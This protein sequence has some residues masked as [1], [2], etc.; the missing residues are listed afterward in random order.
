MAET[1]LDQFGS[2]VGTVLEFAVIAFIFY[3]T[4]IYLDFV[5]KCL[6]NGGGGILACSIILLE[7]FFT[8][9]NCMFS[10]HPLTCIA[11]LFDVTTEEGSP[12]LRCNS[13]ALNVL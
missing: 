9:I 5:Y 12:C 6:H 3:F 11:N 10:A 13:S 1:G 8:V 2:A 7:K 4:Y